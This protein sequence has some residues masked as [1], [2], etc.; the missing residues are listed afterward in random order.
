MN[1]HQSTPTIKRILQVAL[2]AL[3]VS[4]TVRAQAVSPSTAWTTVP[5]VDWSKLKLE[6]F[7]DDELDL[8]YYLSNF[9]RVAN[10]VVETGE[11]RGFIDIAVWRNQENNKP[12]NARIMENI[13]SLAFF[14]STKRPWNQ[15]YGSTAVRERLEAALDFW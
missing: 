12:Y 9:H 2:L 3:F 7:A 1:I 4:S 6:D 14:Y 13:L 15:Y 10:S 11:N 5:P 8:P